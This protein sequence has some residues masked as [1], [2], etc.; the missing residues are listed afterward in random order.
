MSESETILKLKEIY[1][2]LV[3]LSPELSRDD[4]IKMLSD[5][6]KQL[7]YQ[8]YHHMNEQYR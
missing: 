3:R 4:H 7:D 6:I 2:H 8:E 1:E 5:I